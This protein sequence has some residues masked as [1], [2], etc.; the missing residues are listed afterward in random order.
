MVQLIRGT[1]SMENCDKD[2]LSL[3]LAEWA[4][5][6]KTKLRTPVQE[7]KQHRKPS[8]ARLADGQ[9]YVG[10]SGDFVKIYNHV[11]PRIMWTITVKPGEVEGAG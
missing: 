3:L 8:P 2:H 6:N 11:F 7:F 1:D 4:K 10:A 9:V 5:T